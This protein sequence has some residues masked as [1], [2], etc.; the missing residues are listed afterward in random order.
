MYR[1]G[2]SPYDR[3]VTRGEMRCESGPRPGSRHEGA[4]GPEQPRIGIVDDDP[5][6]RTGLRRVLVASE[7]VPEAFATGEEFLRHTGGEGFDCLIFDVR[8][9]GM[10]GLELQRRLLDVGNTTPV[11]FITGH[12][13]CA[14]RQEGL[15]KG[16]V[17]WIEKPFG[18]EELLGWIRRAIQGAGPAPQA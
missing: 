14:A 15:G 17:A 12:Q 6:V 8:M 18:E 11:I 2:C 10:T 9:P 1:S 13:D 4:A 16:A 3:G 7:F 5:S